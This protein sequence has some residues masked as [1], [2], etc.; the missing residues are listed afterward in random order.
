MAVIGQKL[1]K[2]LLV[3]RIRKHVTDRIQAA[4]SFETTDREILLYVDQATAFTMVGQVFGMAKLEGNLA[5]PESYLS[6]YALAALQQDNVSGY[7]YSTLPQP[8]VS[9]PL[10][11]SITRAYFKLAGSG[12]SKELYLIRAK[13]VG[14]RTTLPLPPGGR[15]WVENELIWVAAIDGSSL[16]GLP[17]YVQMVKT[18]TDDWNEVMALPDDA[19]ETIFQNVTSKILQRYGLPQDI[20]KDNLDAGNKS[21]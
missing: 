3:Q 9:L 21:S 11:Y 12:E 10:G 5:T 4:D 13:R 7:W 8:P 1:T 19:I 16:Y 2:K 18:R 14:R 17:L 6:T 15:A 20:V